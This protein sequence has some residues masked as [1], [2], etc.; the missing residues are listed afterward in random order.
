MLFNR[1]P[2]CALSLAAGLA[3]TALGAAPPAL[4]QAPAAKPA[5]PFDALNWKGVWAMQGGTVFDRSSAEPPQDATGHG[6]AG[7]PGTREHPPYNAEWEAKYLQNIKGV[8][9]G[10]WPDPISFCGIPAGMPRVLNLPDT[11]EFVVTPEQTWIL[12]ENGPNAVR[13]YTDGRGH[14]GPD[15]IWPT[16]SGDSVG[17]WEGSTLVFD[18]IGLRGTPHTIIDRTGIVNSDAMTVAVR[19]H[20]IAD[21]IME[22]QI[23]L[24]DP[25][26]FTK[27]WVVIK[28]YRRL[29]K[30]T[31]I[32]D[33]ACNENNRNPVDARGQT[34]MLGGDGKPVDQRGGLN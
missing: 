19:M 33:Y 26:A 15:D 20:K 4:A 32:F 28:R 2:G 27:P 3:L 30:F 34:R 24:T 16:Y 22:A 31:R 13:I 18:T 5:A 14:L 10:T 7:Q 12:S 17:H 21:D 29:P 8:A 25:K 6:G 1:K 9:D 11:F 23:T